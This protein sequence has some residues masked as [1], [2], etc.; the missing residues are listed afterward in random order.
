[1]TNEI[2]LPK[3]KTNINLNINIGVESVNKAGKPYFNNVVNNL[4]CILDFC[5]LVNF[6]TFIFCSIKLLIFPTWLKPLKASF[7]VAYGLST[8]NLIQTIQVNKKIE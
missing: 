7:R 8:I 1:M 4:N 3:I 2:Y 6:Y 5:L